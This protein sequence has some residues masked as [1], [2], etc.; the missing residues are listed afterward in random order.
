M[1]K[2]GFTRIPVQLKNNTNADTHQHAPHGIR[3]HP[4][5]KKEAVRKNER[6]VLTR[7]AELADKNVGDK[8]GT[9]RNTEKSGELNHV[10]LWRGIRASVCEVH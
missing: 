3:R 7:S 8:Q 6:C 10:D 1:T 2:G 9:V 5:R 4:L